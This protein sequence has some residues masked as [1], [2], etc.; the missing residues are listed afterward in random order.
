MQVG[1]F[2]NLQNGKTVPVTQAMVRNAYRSVKKKEEWAYKDAASW[3]KSK[4]NLKDNLYI[5]WNRLASGSYFPP[6]VREVAIP[7]GKGKGTRKLG[8][9]PLWDKVGQMVIKQEIASRFETL[10]SSH[11]YG[12]RPGKNAHEALREVRSNCF[13]YSWVVDLDIKGFFDEIDHELLM[14]AVGKHVEEQWICM[15]I[16][17]WLTAPITTP[18]G[19]V[20]Y[21]QGKG[22]PQGGVISPLLANI[23]LHYSLDKWLSKHYPRIKFVRYADDIVLHCSSKAE[24]EELLSA[25]RERLGECKLQLNEQK[26]KIVYCKDYRRQGKYKGTKFDFLGYSFQPREIYHTK[27]K[28]AI[29][30]TPGISQQSKNKIREVIRKTEELSRTEIRL[31]KIAKRLNEQLRGWINYYSRYRGYLL[32]RVFY[33]LDCRLMKWLRKK[34]KRLKGSRRRAW[35]MLR[36]IYKRMPY[37]FEHWRQG[38]STVCH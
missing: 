15:Y 6:P 19:E 28:R 35:S 1:I 3:Q 36:G 38:Y 31:E 10:F 14:R 30:F 27:H 26:T 5:L 12:Y 16:R 21:R 8:I 17:R 9:A 4:E 34:Y 32:E 7:K 24:A 29:G 22:T 18:E 33:S 13:S 25:V 23:F 11:S 37:L 20:K 2:D